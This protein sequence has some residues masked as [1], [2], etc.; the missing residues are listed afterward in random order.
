MSFLLFEIPNCNAEEAL[1]LKR[2]FLFA[3]S[4][5]IEMYNT[6]VFCA[7]AMKYDAT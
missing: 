4:Y 7:I 6:F 5:F 2:I 3:P 1:R